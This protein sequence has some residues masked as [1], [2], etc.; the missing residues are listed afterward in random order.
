MLFFYLLKHIDALSQ[1][2][3]NCTRCY[4]NRHLICAFQ[5][6]AYTTKT[7]TRLFCGCLTDT[8]TSDRDDGGQRRRSDTSFLTHDRVLLCFFFFFSFAVLLYDTSPHTRCCR[9]DSGFCEV[10]MTGLCWVLLSF[11]SW[12]LPDRLFDS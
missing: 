8:P 4:D 5:T 11:C 6:Y 10:P 3:T 9:N 7:R 2:V 12:N 1:P